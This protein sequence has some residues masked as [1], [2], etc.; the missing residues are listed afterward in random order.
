MNWQALGFKD[1]PLKTSPITRDTLTLFTGHEEES[2]LCA[3][4][5]DGTNSRLVIE[6]AR[7]VGTT[8]FANHL[9]F[10]KDIEKN[11][12]T[13]RTEIKVESGWR[14]ETLM[15]AIISNIIREIDLLSDNKTLVTDDKFQSAKAMCARIAE[16]YRSFGIEAFGFGANYG[17]QAGIVSQPTIVPS[18]TLGHHFEDLIHLIQKAGYQK[19]ILIQLNNLDIGAIHSS[20]QMKYL[21]DALRDYTQIE[22]SHWLLVGD[23]GLRKFI[24]QSVDRLDDIIS[25]EVTL[26]PLPESQLDEMLDKRVA[27]YA[28]SAQIDFP[29][30]SDVFHFLY[31]ITNGRLR[32]VFG[33]V[34]RL[35]NRL[36]VGDLND[37]VTLSLAKPMLAKLGKDRLKRSDITQTEEHVLKRLVTF[38]GTSISSMAKDLEKTPQYIGR[39]LM[40]LS[41]KNLL[42]VKQEGRDKIYTP[43]ID[44]VIAYSDDI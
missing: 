15:T 8:S 2:N 22:G 4:A 14:L 23:V 10:N 18:T 43:S 32:Y 16:T 37:K 39:I 28:Q 5:L 34:S 7:G 17:K 11:Y 36:Y 19:G 3:H 33:L 42:S 29:V 44:A 41:H 38:P 21:L 26:S 20:E 13:P 6:G 9:R 40:S 24:A 30:D 27:F 12:F 35:M 25:H 1:D 31:Q